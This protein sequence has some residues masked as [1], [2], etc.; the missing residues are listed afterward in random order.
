MFV[1]VCARGRIY[2]DTGG[3][4]YFSDSATPGGSP[5]ENFVMF[6]ENVKSYPC[7]PTIAA[8]PQACQKKYL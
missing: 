8:P 6:F 2:Y 4:R 7:P 3:K 1:G 5:D